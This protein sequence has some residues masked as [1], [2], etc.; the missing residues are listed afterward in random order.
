MNFADRPG[1]INFSGV[2]L[3]EEFYP[4]LMDYLSLLVEHLDL[5]LNKCV[6]I[7]SIH[8]KLQDRVIY[9]INTILRQIIIFHLV[10]LLRHYC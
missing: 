3:I 5:F 9:Y 10:F 2:R 7:F 1:E 8:A 6:M 4:K